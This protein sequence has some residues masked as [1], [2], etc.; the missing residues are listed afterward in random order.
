MIG[1]VKNHQGR[2]VQPPASRIAAYRTGGEWLCFDYETIEVAAAP[3]VFVLWI[4]RS[5]SMAGVMEAVKDTARHFLNILPAHAECLVGSFS[6]DRSPAAKNGGGGQCS[7]ENFDLD[8]I[9]AGGGTDIYEPLA[10]SYRTLGYASFRDHQKAVIVITDG[11]ITTDPAQSSARKSALLAQKRDAPTFVY[12]LGDREETHLP[13]LADHFIDN[14]GDVR[15]GLM[16]YFDI[17]GAAY[18]KQTVLTIKACPAG[19]TP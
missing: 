5:G 19:N 14:R 12:W 18:K 13:G 4:D 7:P 15:A 9:T 10:D 3:M 8:A 2:L 16:R 1:L 11:R 17:L 6:D